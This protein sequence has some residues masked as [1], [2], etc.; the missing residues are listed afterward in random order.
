VV[1]FADRCGRGCSPVCGRGATC[2]GFQFRNTFFPKPSARNSSKR[3]APTTRR[4]NRD[5]LT[6][7]RGLGT[8]V[9]AGGHLPF[10]HVLGQACCIMN[11]KTERDGNRH[12]RSIH[13]RWK[14]ASKTRFGLA[15]LVRFRGA[16]TCGWSIVIGPN[17]GRSAFRPI[18]TGTGGVVRKAVC[19]RVK[20]RRGPKQVK[21][22]SLARASDPG[23][24]HRRGQPTLVQRVN[25]EDKD[26]TRRVLQFHS[27]DVRN[28]SDVPAPLGGSTQNRTRR[29]KDGGPKTRSRICRLLYGTD[30]HWPCKPIRPAWQHSEIGAAF[31]WPQHLG[32]DGFVPRLSTTGNNEE[33]VK[34][35]VTLETYQLEQFNKFSWT[36]LAEVQDGEQSL[37]DSHRRSL[38]LAGWA[39][40]VSHTNFGLAES[41]WRVVVTRRWVTSKK[42]AS[43]GIQK[44][45]HC[46]TC[47][48]IIA[49]AWCRERRVSAPGTGTFSYPMSVSSSAS[50]H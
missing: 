10:P 1:H 3:S 19:D 24:D 49:L 23:F 16:S 47:S 40:P 48:S 20:A 5:Q 45:C 6:V 32:I 25:R 4:E 7:Y 41:S 2:L 15:H 14:S 18:F 21:A 8:R 33:T 28:N 35:F 42:V 17:S 31:L 22:N 50:S 46:V 26:Q 44:G 11:R 30:S 38:R 29:S 34:N 43:D 39:T 9:Y 13:R 36:R 37:L 12:H 27:D